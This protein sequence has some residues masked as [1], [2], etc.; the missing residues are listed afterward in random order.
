MVNKNLPSNTIGLKST[1]GRTMI[2]KKIKWLLF[3]ASDRT[4]TNFQWDLKSKKAAE[5]FDKHQQS[6]YIS[7]PLHLKW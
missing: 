2:L 4:Q 3:F 1:H 7:L 5:K 6:K